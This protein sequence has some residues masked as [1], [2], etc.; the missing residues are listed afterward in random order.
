MTKLETAREAV[1]AACLDLHRTGVVSRAQS[2]AYR[3][4]INAWHKLDA[5][6]HDP[7]RK[8]VA[9]ARVAVNRMRA[10]GSEWTNALTAAEKAL[11]IEPGEGG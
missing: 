10:G 4:A 3:K 8:F 1:V 11:G 6:E 7:V 9:M 5:Q 2:E